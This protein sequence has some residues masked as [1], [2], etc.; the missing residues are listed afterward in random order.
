MGA[1]NPH[2]LYF[3]AKFIVMKVQNAHS[4]VVGKNDN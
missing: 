2:F 4:D 1:G 3:F